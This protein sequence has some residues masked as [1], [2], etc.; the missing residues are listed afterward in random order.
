[1]KVVTVYSGYKNYEK[2]I[3][4]LRS[5]GLEDQVYRGYHVPVYDDEYDERGCKILRPVP[6]QK[7]ENPLTF[8]HFGNAGKQENQ[9]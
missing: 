9:N 4:R 2:T 7:L 6:T 3:D 1:M 5:R 8:I